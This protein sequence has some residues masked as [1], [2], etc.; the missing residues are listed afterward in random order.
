MQPT[1][2]LSSQ[3]ILDDGTYQ[4]FSYPEDLGGVGLNR[5]DTAL[6]ALKMILRLSCADTTFSNLL[7]SFSSKYGFPKH[8]VDTFDQYSANL[9]EVAFALLE[10]L[11]DCKHIDPHKYY[12]WDFMSNGL[13]PFLFRGANEAEVMQSFILNYRKALSR[14]ANRHAKSK[15]LESNLDM[16]F[17]TLFGMKGL[18]LGELLS[19]RFASQIHIRDLAEASVYT[20][21]KYKRAA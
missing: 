20:V 13:M 15:E 7:F 10:Y 16:A 12:R 18:K 8:I 9:E 6:D 4:F 14:N 2:K 17:R 3:L 1:N 21:N 19:Y 5:A 11:Y